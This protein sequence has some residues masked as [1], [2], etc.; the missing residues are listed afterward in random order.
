MYSIIFQLHVSPSVT[1]MFYWGEFTK[2]RYCTPCVF[3]TK[4]GSTLLGLVRSTACGLSTSET[5]SS[6]PAP[7]PR[8]LGS[9][10]DLF[11]STHGTRL[12]CGAKN[13]GLLEHP[14]LSTK[15]QG[16]LDSLLTSYFTPILF[17]CSSVFPFTLQCIP[18]LVKW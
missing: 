9:M 13:E 17:L 5:R 15:H 4:Q 7:R 18:F 12:N 10:P 8:S 1:V 6:P 2:E 3:A 16:T 14:P 11:F